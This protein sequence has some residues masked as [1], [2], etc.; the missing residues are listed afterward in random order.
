MSTG[1]IYIVSQDERYLNLLRASAE[2][3]K[4]AMPD[5]PVTVFSQF[6]IEGPHFDNVT[7]VK[8]T[9]DGFYDKTRLMLESPYE[10]TLFID[11]DIY[12]AEPFSELFTLLDRFDCAATH[13]EYLNTDWS[14]NYPRPDIPAS[15]P[16]FNTG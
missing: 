16:E 8:P 5:L 10:R 9:C 1:A 7:L 12:V 14:N 3:L 11:A 4:R 15:F 2:S 13:E 6:P